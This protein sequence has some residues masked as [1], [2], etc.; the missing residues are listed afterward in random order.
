MNTK[1]KS[2]LIVE[3]DYKIRQLVKLYLEK[4]GYEVFEAG[5]GEEALTS[6]N[7]FDPC[8]VILDLMLPKMSGEDVCQI[9][10]ADLKAEVPLIML[11]AKVDE[12]ERI[13]GLKMGA[14]DYVTK[15]FSPA[16]LVARVESVLR[17]TGHRCSKITFRGL[18]V[19]PLRGEVHYRGE[20][21]Q[22]TKHEFKLLYFFMRH[23]NQILSREQIIEELYPNHEKMVTERTIDVHVGK[24]REKL[25]F[26]GT[27][28]LI[29]TVRG[30]GYRFAAFES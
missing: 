27:Q 7:S 25:K 9:L 8:F 19:K 22:L 3:D 24:L 28:E 26:D 18:T 20:T 2:I 23:P 21:I 4:E 29:E 1:G 15:P 11:T 5:D 10:R 6:F 13:K 30:M 12:E 17:R 14:D 16:E